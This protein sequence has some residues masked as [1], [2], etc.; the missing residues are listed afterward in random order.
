MTRAEDD[1]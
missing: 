1:L